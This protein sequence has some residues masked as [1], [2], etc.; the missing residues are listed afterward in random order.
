MLKA[1]GEPAVPRRNQ[2]TVFYRSE[3]RERSLKNTRW[4]FSGSSSLAGRLEN[5]LAVPCSQIQHHIDLGLYINF[6]VG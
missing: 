4:G 2:A 6:L 1:Y 3:Y 5:Y